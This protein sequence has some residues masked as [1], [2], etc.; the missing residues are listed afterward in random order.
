MRNSLLVIRHWSLVLFL[1]AGF[2]SVPLAQKPE[3][4]AGEWTGKYK[5][6]QSE[7]DLFIKVGRANGPWTVAV[8]AVSSYG[9][10][11]FRP[12]TDVTVEGGKLSFTVEWGSPVR[13]K[14]E[15]KQDVLAGELASDHF[16]GTWTSKR[17]TD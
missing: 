7:G 8:K 1:A 6:A 9:E 12:T 17:K 2:S 10:G 14:G 13:F 5:T 16:S 11:E 15:L 4:L 3:P